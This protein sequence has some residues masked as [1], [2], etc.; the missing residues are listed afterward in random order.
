MFSQPVKLASL[1]AGKSPV[2]AYDMAGNVWEW[3]ADWHDKDYYRRAPGRNAP[4]RV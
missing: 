3:V 1:H 4:I 2:G